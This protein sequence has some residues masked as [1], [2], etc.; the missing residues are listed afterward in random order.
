MCRLFPGLVVPR[1]W[2]RFQ[3]FHQSISSV[4]CIFAPQISQIH[5]DG[6]LTSNSLPL[7]SVRRALPYAERPKAVGLGQ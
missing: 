1:R 4:F 2:R 5:M 6:V 7:A 3:I